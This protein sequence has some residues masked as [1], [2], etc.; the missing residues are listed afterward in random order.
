MPHGR[1]PLC[2]AWVPL[3]GTH[4]MR[5]SVV[6]DGC[7]CSLALSTQGTQPAVAGCTRMACEEERDAGEQGGWR[8]LPCC[9]AG[10]LHGLA[11]SRPILGVQSRM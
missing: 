11:P 1:L 7:T 4:V 3:A 6:G 9:D 2:G 10:G 8:G 5:G